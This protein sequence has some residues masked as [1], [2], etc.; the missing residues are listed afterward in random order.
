MSMLDGKRTIVSVWHNGEPV[1]LTYAI[2]C[3]PNSQR[4]PWGAC[5]RIEIYREAGSGGYR[6]AVACYDNRGRIAERIILGDGWSVVY[7][8]EGHLSEAMGL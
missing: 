2:P 1:A 7:A 8:T 6:P 4:R 5:S 3:R